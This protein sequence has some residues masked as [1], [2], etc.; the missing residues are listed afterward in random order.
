[1]IQTRTQRI[2]RGFNRF[3]I[4]LGS[5]VFLIGLSIAYA[6]SAEWSKA[7]DVFVISCLGATVLYALSRAIG[8]VL[9]GFIGD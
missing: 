2:H 7:T 6:V 1:M 4:L 9:A 5:I 8:W 3:G